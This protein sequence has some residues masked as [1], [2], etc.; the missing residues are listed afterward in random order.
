METTNI[1]FNMKTM[2]LIIAMT[3]LTIASA[4]IAEVKTSETK[5]YK[6]GMHLDIDKLI[7]LEYLRTAPAHCGTIP[8]EITYEDSTGE[9]HIVEYLYPDTS[10]CAH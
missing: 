8:A 4:A 3:A 5:A 9:V 10:G 1:T 2:K 7:K 6:Y